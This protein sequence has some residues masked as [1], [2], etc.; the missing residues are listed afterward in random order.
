MQQKCIETE[1]RKLAEMA[2][3]STWIEDTKK[4]LEHL[5]L[6]LN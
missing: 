5:V 1:K 4:V 6:L 3:Y 2:R